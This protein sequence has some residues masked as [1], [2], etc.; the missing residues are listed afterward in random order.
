LLYYCHISWSG[1]SVTCFQCLKTRESGLQV[2]AELVAK[3][4]RSEKALWKEKR[5]HLLDQERLNIRQLALKI[6][7]NSTYGCLGF[8]GSRFYAKPL[9]E[10]ITSKGREILQLTVST[11]KNE[12]GMEVVYGDTDSIM[13]DSG[14]EDIL[15]AREMA[16][17]VSKAISKSYKLLELGV[18]GNLSPFC[19]CCRRKSTPAV[20]VKCDS[21]GK[22]T[23]QTLEKKGLDLVRRDCVRF[24][25]KS[26]RKVLGFLTSG[27]PGRRY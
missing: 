6:L 24:V 1:H 2:L 16:N 9:A 15:K 12:L 14:C 5:T 10:L 26:G 11:V 21:D 19:C 18:D 20:A 27:K 13:V 23:G 4:K 22:I 25:E 7:A 8:S 17:K 3:R